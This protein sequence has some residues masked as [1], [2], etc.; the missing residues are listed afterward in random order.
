MTSIAVA[1]KCDWRKRALAFLVLLLAACDVGSQAPSTGPALWR[2]VDADT[3]IWLFGTVHVLPRDLNWRDAAF[4]AAFSESDV[5]YLEVPV[6][7]AGA[8]ALAEQLRRYSSLPAGQQLDAWLQPQ[9]RARL[10]RLGDRYGLNARALQQRQ[11]WAAA[12]QLT[13]AQAQ[14]Q[15][16]DPAAGVEQVLTRE[17]ARRGLPL[18]YF[19][20]AHE[21][22]ALLATLPRPTQVAFLRATLRQLEEEPE[23]KARL[24]RLWVEGNTQAL[25]AEFTADFDASGEVLRTALLDTRNARW[26][27]DIAEI[28]ETQPGDVFIAVGVAHLVGDGSV[29]DLLEARNLQVVRVN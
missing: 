14:A 24:D 12:L 16:Q 25:A 20:T 6:D 21:Q 5:V 18:R 17:A 27:E 29:V 15:G 28:L 26:A 11:P 13:L 7:A 8:A 23:A 3:R 2:L 4:E 22:V 10:Q 19:E 9:D 1:P